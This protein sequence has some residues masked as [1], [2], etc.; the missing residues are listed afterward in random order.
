MDFFKKLTQQLEDKAKELLGD[1]AVNEIKDTAKTLARDILEKKTTS[2]KK[3]AGVAVA[4][5]APSFT[6]MEKNAEAA[7]IQKEVIRNFKDYCETTGQCPQWADDIAISCQ[8]QP[9]EFNISFL[10]AKADDAANRL[11]KSY[12]T[13]IRENRPYIMM[14]NRETNSSQTIIF[15]FERAQQK[16]IDALNGI[17]EK[18]AATQPAAQDPLSEQVHQDYERFCF[19]KH[20]P[21]HATS[22][23]IRISSIQQKD[24]TVVTFHH[25]DDEDIFLTIQPYMKKLKKIVPG[26][27]IDNS[28]D[29]DTSII[30]PAASLDDFTKAVN[31]S[32][33]PLAEKF[34]V[35][36]TGTLSV[37]RKDAQAD[38]IKNGFNVL[39][40]ISSKA[41][42]VVAGEKAGAKL[43]KAKELRIPILTEEEWNKVKFKPS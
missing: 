31:L 23:C 43:H 13:H 28:E 20:Y 4:T 7:F 6:Q 30:I 40:D 32:A 21:E 16:F 12:L 14:D 33:G 15:F 34:N 18:P 19:T 35:V 25:G 22:D 1:Q 41:N 39:G 3:D 2:P 36:F 8:Y 29:C 11:V 5:T 10:H 24:K 26:I 27:A 17:D 9:G 37:S 42:Y 38:A